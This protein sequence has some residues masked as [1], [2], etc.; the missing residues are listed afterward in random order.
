MSITSDK[1]LQ[2]LLTIKC[3]GASKNSKRPVNMAQHPTTY[4]F[5]NKLTHIYF[6]MY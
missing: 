6:M 1:N 2:C 3:G 5:S 4:E